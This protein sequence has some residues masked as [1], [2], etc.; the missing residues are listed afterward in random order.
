MSL[1]SIEPSSWSC[2]MSASWFD[3]RRN[4]ISFDTRRARRIDSFF[5][6][7]SYKYAYHNGSFYSIILM[8]TFIG[9]ICLLSDQTSCSIHSSEWNQICF[10]QDH[11]NKFF[12]LE[13]VFKRHRK[14]VQST[15]WPNKSVWIRGWHKRGLNSKS[16]SHQHM[17]SLLCK[18]DK[19]K[20]AAV[21]CVNRLGRHILNVYASD[22]LGNYHVRFK[23][24]KV[25][26]IQICIRHR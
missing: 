16:L 22:E 25:T 10:K 7:I 5:W 17:A 12:I 11:N 21:H 6:H 26:C 4:S 18:R 15:R 8:D 1:V 24:T 13:P 23:Y 2:D 20:S 14:P 9:D 3:M 19:H